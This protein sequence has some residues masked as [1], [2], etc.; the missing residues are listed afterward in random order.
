MVYVQRTLCAGCFPATSTAFCCPPIALPDCAWIPDVSVVLRSRSSGSCAEVVPPRATC[1]A[2]AGR[3]CCLFSRVTQTAGTW[4]RGLACDKGKRGSG[5]VMKEKRS[6]GSRGPDIRT[7]QAQD[8]H[9]AQQ[10]VQPV[11]EL[12]DI[13]RTVVCLWRFDIQLYCWALVYR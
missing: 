6:G 4:L 2:Y 5:R 11:I 9:P 12:L 10:R 3:L 8:F 13:G 1:D 7:S